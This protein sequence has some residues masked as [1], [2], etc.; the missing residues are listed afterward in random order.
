MIFPPASYVANTYMRKI[1][2]STSGVYNFT[3]AAGIEDGRILGISN[4]EQDFTEADLVNLYAMGANPIMYAKNVGFY[5]ET[6]FTASI[7]KL[8]ALSYLHVREVLIDLENELYAMLLKYQWKF[9][10]SAI[11]A[12][13]K[14]EADEICQRFVDRSALYAFENIID[15]SNNTPTLIDNQFGLLE[16]KIE[17]VKAMGIIVNVINVMA[18]GA[19]GASSGFT[20]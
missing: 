18:T 20:A 13:I 19:L 16:T 2:S 6:E 9:N 4:V 1:N 15:E 10:T 5:I 17:I 3:V 7:A 8:S 12:K 11:R 14:R